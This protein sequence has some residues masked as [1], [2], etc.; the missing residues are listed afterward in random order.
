LSAAA[1]NVKRLP[2]TDEARAAKRFAVA[3][4]GK[5]MMADDATPVELW[6]RHAEESP[7][8]SDDE[9]ERLFIAAARDNVDLIQ[10]IIE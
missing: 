9:I 4:G 10:Q 8:T 3:L 1:I 5:M 7:H 2:K 6:Q